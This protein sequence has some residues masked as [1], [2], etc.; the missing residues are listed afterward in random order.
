MSEP[1]WS[2]R[3]VSV[4]DDAMQQQL[5]DVLTDCV[6]RGASI[7]FMQPLTRERVLR[8]WR[9]VATGVAAGER[10]LLVA[11]DAAGICGSVQLLVAMPDNQPHRADVAI[12]AGASG[13]SL[14]NAQAVPR[15][16]TFTTA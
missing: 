5:A 9:G 3:R 12:P 7:G 2:I 16:A 15:I 11:E 4:L 13:I 10:V 8:F 14:P 6:E 1:T